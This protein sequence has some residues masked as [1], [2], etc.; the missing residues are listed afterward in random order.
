MNIIDDLI[1]VNKS[2]LKKAGRLFSNNWQII[3]TGFAYSVL[4]IILFSIIGVLFRI[5]VVGFFAGIITFIATS[6]MISNYFHLLYNIIKHG[7]FNLQD[8]KDGFKAYLWKVYGVLFIGWLAGFLFD[9]VLAPILYRTVVSPGTLNFII[10]FLILILLNA[11]PETIY[12]KF[13][14]PWESIV[15]AFNYV[16]ENW[17]EWFIPN[18]ILIGILYLTTGRLINDL[19]AINFSFGFSLSLKS[20]L[21]YIIGQILFSFIMIYRGVLFEVLSTST[22]RKRIFMRDLYK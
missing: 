7:R 16:K 9:M 2:T 18:I 11:L 12:Q 22:R 1:F 8:F 17:I 3:F 14:S 13:Y 20:I 6:A 5:P 19:F 15:Y 4:N 21:L 10:S